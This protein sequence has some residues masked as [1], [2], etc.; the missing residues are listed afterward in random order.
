MSNDTLAVVIPV[1]NEESCID[2]VIH[3]WGTA[4]SK[5]AIDFNII[6]VN[7]GSR[8]QTASILD[9]LCH[10]HPE[11]VVIHQEN[12]GH[13]MA[14][15]NGYIEAIT[16]N[17][18][19]IFQTDSDDQF[20]PEDFKSFWERRNESPA[21][22]GHRQN[23]KDPLH[24]KV[25]SFFLKKVIYDFFQADIPDANI[26]YRLFKASYLKSTLACLTPGLFAPNIFLSILCFRSLNGC[27]VIPVQHFERKDEAKLIRW[28]LIKACLDSFWD[29]TVFS[30]QLDKKVQY[31]HGHLKDDNLIVL[32]QGK[33]LNIA[34]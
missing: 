12:Q 5:L 23:R 25:I 30:Y 15:K 14:V 9:N 13:G 24:R 6:I 26:P 4:L 27:P 16:R 31:I 2:K 1:Y 3:D 10:K 17:Y 20:T 18:D 33:D 21:I 34:A 19:Y 29:L 7:D 28:G 11:L 32:P 8:D 22:F